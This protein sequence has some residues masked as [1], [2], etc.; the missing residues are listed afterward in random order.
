MGVDAVDDAI[1]AEWRELGF[2][3]EVDDDAAE[4][5]VSGSIAG[6]QRFAGLLT[7]YACTP[8]KELISEHEHF[9]PYYLK[10]VTSNAPGIDGA[11]IHGTPADLRRLAEIILAEVE[12]ATIG[13]RVRIRDYAS[14][15]AFALVLD[16]RPNDF[17][18]SSADRSLDSRPGV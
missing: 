7:R 17:D 10:I 1:R 18:P 9:G 16:L 6:I 4:W 13:D 5:R 8:V 2:F 12:R 14:D 3:C 11:A 15:S